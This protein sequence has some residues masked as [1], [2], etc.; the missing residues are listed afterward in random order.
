[1]IVKRHR[2]V[3]VLLIVCFVMVHPTA[4]AKGAIDWRQCVV[5]IPKY[6]IGKNETSWSWLPSNPCGFRYISPDEIRRSPRRVSYQTFGDSTGLR[7]FTYFENAILGIPMPIMKQDQRPP[8]ISHTFDSNRTG[9]IAYHNFRFVAFHNVLER[10]LQ[11]DDIFDKF[12]SV[13]FLFTL[14]NHDV[15]WRGRRVSNETTT[16][17]YWDRHVTDMVR[18]LKT[19]IEL[20][21]RKS[22]RGKLHIIY[23]Q[24]YFQNCNATRYT[25]VFSDCR[26]HIRRTVN[27]F[28]RVLQ[29]LLW[30]LNIP[31]IPTDFMFTDN[32]K[33]CKMTDGV[34]L[35]KPCM[36]VE[37]QLW[38]NV[39]ALLQRRCVR[40]GY[41]TSSSSPPLYTVRELGAMVGDNVDY[42]STVLPERVMGTDSGA[43]C[44]DDIISTANSTKNTNNNQEAGPR[45]S[46]S[47]N[48]DLIFVGVVFLSF[49]MFILWS[50]MQ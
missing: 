42:S 11:L 37:A 12:D 33:A 19:L 38:W 43:E 1:M 8:F 14:G 40:H 20:R 39:L 32:Y 17:R 22:G 18:N 31:V 46:F 4:A 44:S 21:N 47:M 9:E 28:R 29:P 3:M 10:V 30:Q 16:R 13:V 7:I 23:R 24:E 49:S 50:L 48:M 34:H 2:F 6:F 27:Y 26:V 25:D 35:D 36:A 15:N 45:T 5:D 41:N